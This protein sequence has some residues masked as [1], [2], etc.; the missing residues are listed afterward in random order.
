MIITLRQGTYSAGQ[1]VAVQGKTKEMLGLILGSFFAEDG[2]GIVYRV[3]IVEHH[4]LHTDL[5]MVPEEK[6]RA[7]DPQA[8]WIGN[9]QQQE[10]SRP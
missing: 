1:Y 3:R 6:V 4:T 10:A 2:V 9:H 5:G 8:W 7:V